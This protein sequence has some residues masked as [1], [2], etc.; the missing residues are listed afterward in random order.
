MESSIVN[1]SYSVV[2]NNVGIDLASWITAISTLTMAIFAGFALNTWKNELKFQKKLEIYN[3][4]YLLFFK[5]ERFL[6]D[7]GIIYSRE[8]EL[9]CNNQ[10]TSFSSE[11]ALFKSK[12][13]IINDNDLLNEVDFCFENIQKT[14]AWG[15]AEELE[16]G[17]IRATYQYETFIQKY[18]CDNDFKNNLKLSVSKIQRLCEEKQIKL[19]K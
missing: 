7:L 15:K 2:G 1:Y 4:L 16:N 12:V 9:Y 6:D 11:I 5:I 10:I 8:G 14:F 17:T 3:D 19:Y 13:K 18:I